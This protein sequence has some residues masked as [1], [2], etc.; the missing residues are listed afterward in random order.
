LIEVLDELGHRIWVDVPGE[1]A[2]AELERAAPR[3]A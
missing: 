1:H 2:F 3:G